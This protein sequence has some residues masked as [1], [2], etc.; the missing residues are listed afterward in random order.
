MESLSSKWTDTLLVRFHGIWGK[1][2]VDHIAGLPYE[3]LAQSWSE[4]LTGLS[5][6]QIKTGLTQVTLHC[7]WPCAIAEFRAACLPK[8]DERTA[9]QRAFAAS[10]DTDQSRRLTNG[11]WAERRQ[12]GLQHLD[13]LKASLRGA[14]TARVVRSHVTLANGTWT[15][16]MDAA[17]AAD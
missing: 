2:W 16:A 11:T 17:W 3:V 13:A 12:V 14:G 6:Q 7:K 10:A 5:A 9:E 4:G 8:P 15:A 1:A